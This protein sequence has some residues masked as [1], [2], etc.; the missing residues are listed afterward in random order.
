MTSTT[1]GNCWGTIAHY[2][3]TECT[4]PSSITVI[5][6]SPTHSQ[7]HPAPTHVPEVPMRRAMIL[8]LVALG[9]AACSNPTAPKDCSGVVGGSNTCMTK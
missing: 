1:E 2:H 3:D 4:F 9:L 5:A 7:N 6:Y 8:A